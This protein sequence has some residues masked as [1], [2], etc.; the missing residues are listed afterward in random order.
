MDAIKFLLKAHHNDWFLWREVAIK[1]HSQLCSANCTA[2]QIKNSTTSAS[3]TTTNV[4][5]DLCYKRA[6]VGK[7]CICVNAN[8]HKVG[9]G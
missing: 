9:Q 8:E 1:V 2:L 6:I 4:A 7:P 3:V 5:D